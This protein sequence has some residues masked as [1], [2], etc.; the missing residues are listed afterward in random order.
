MKFI[1]IQKIEN[2]EKT[3]PVFDLQT[4]KNHNFF[5]NNILVHN[6]LIYQEH[7]QSI[8]HKLAG[9]PLDETDAVRKAFTKKD[10]SNKEKALSE[11]KRLRDEFTLKC[12]EINDIDEKTSSIIFDDLDK[13]AAY[14]FNKAH[15]VSYATIS[16]MC[17]HLLTYFPDE[18][19]TTYVDYCINDKGKAS[20]KEDPKAIA[21]SEAKALGYVIGKPDINL[22]EKDY[23]IRDKILIPSFGSLKHVGTAVLNEINEYRPYKTLE[24]LLFSKT[25]LGDIWR[26][27]KLNKRAFSTLAR[28][29][30]FNS[31]ELVGP[32]KMFENYRQLHYIVAEKADEL[33]KAVSRKKKTHIEDLARFIEE[34]KQLPDW[35]SE[36]KI[37]N[38]IEL[39]GNIDL[40]LL[41][42]QEI[43]DYFDEKNIVS[44]DDRLEDDQ[45]VW[46]IV[47]NS[48]AAQTKTGKHYL[49]MKVYGPNNNSFNCFCWNFNPLKDKII[50]S[51]TLVVGKFKFSDFGFSCF[52]GSLEIV[53]LS[54]K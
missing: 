42:P 13:C 39:S 11:R 20:G 41:V 37:K 35:N 1:K 50:P 43:N 23:T 32:G 51:H 40:S 26:H 19:I 24:D 15:A 21:L 31:M 10:L 7:L 17:A 47:E 53:G 49:R 36:E 30:A 27:S 2:T 6:C 18:W 54:N 8:Y 34:A 29:E 46:C 14:L 5:A 9:V 48:S 28:V 33:K 52:F 44:I 45:L 25:A 4:N 38:S 22:S 12:K 3:V 16:Y